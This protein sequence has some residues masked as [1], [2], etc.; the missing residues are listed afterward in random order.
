M[1][2]PDPFDFQPVV[3]RYAVMGNPIGH[4]LSPKIHHAFAQQC[5]IE[6][7][8]SRIQ[9]EPGGFEQAVS[10]FAAQAGAGLNVTLP[11]KEAAWRL[12]RRVG[13]RLSSRAALAA[14]VNTLKFADD[15]GVLGD[16]TD[17]IGLVRDLEHNL[18]VRLPGRRVLILG[19][20]GAACGILG[21]LLAGRPQRVCIANRT[22]HKAHQLAARFQ[23]QQVELAGGGYAEVDV[24]PYDLI[25]NATAASLQGALP[26]VNAGCVAPQTVVYDL[27]YASRPTPFMQW[28]RAAGAALASDGLGMLVEQAAE[29]FFLWH[30]QRPQTAPVLAALRQLPRSA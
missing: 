4:S 24:Q 16:N 14:A 28:G 29:S 27:L 30:E 25:V 21:A 15:G 26:P 20:G 9:V 18:R 6:L 11:L 19:A 8:Y 22:A 7:E 23:S 10:H 1:S 12:C 17:G 5:G 3:R 2:M 13:H